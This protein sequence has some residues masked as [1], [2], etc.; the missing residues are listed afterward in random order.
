MLKGSRLQAIIS[1][2]DRAMKTGGRG[3]P[4]LV[5]DQ[6]AAFFIRST[7]SDADQGLGRTPAE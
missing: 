6:A 3:E 7:S 1:R 4:D 5:S 2:R